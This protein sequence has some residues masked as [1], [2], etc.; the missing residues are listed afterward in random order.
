MAEKKIIYHLFTYAYDTVV[1]F[2]RV[3]T[4]MMISRRYSST[5]TAS[6]RAAVLWSTAKAE[7]FVCCLVSSAISDVESV[8]YRG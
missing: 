7:G 1:G 4:S 6:S 3:K 5:P 8:G 2:I